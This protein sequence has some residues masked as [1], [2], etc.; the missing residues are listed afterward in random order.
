MIPNITRILLVLL[1]LT[2]SPVAVSH[3]VA[4]AAPLLPRDAVV[5]AFGDSLT[6]GTGAAPRESYPAVLARLIGRP[7]VNEGI[8]GETSGEGLARL[9][10]VLERRKPALLILCLG[11]NDLLRGMGMGQVAENLRTMIRIA[12]GKRIAVVLLA[13]PLLGITLSEEPLQI[14][15][16]TGERSAVI[17]VP[18]PRLTLWPA[19]VYR[20]IGRDMGL[21]VEEQALTAILS[22]HSL[23][24]DPIHPNAAGYLQLAEA[25]A[26]LLRAG[27]FI[28]DPS[29]PPPLGRPAPS[30]R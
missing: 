19:P 28:E 16:A 14:E 20:E 30:R 12:R 1:S 3:C 29:L 23:R 18:S 11:A 27:G 26:S 17:E 10:E 15:I 7:V 5:L 22:N 25:I 13:V 21:P 4:G 8:P 9:P 24:S 6:Y 2:I